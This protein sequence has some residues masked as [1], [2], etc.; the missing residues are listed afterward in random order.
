MT[1]KACQE[2]EDTAR[3]RFTLHSYFAY[4][5]ER[6]TVLLK[7][8]ANVNYQ[9]KQKGET[10]VCPWSTSQGQIYDYTKGGV[11]TTTYG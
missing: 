7:H 11:L 5:L 1:E 6:T 9:R 3:E 8:K 10:V 4:H 2:M